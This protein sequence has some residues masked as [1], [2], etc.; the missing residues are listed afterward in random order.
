MLGWSMDQVDWEKREV[1]LN[2]HKL[3]S[4]PD[5]VF[6]G[7]HMEVMAAGTKTTTMG[8]RVRMTE[9]FLRAYEAW[10][11][12]RAQLCL[13][14]GWQLDG[15]EGRGTVVPGVSGGPMDH[16]FARNLLATIEA[17]AGVR[18]APPSHFRHSTETTNADLGVDR[19]ATAETE[20]HSEKVATAHY[21]GQSEAR[22]ALIARVAQRWRDQMDGGSTEADLIDE[23]FVR[24]DP[25]SEDDPQAA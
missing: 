10:L 2:R 7:R 24:V 14:L 13:A 19:K 6:G 5:S 16:H 23:G 8:R 3:L 12:V 25:D 21:I 17:G 4:I 11:P 1:I 18:T 22:R 20:G 15:A 9:E